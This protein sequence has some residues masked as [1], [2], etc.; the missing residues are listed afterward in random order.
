MNNKWMLEVSG[1]NTRVFTNSRE[2]IAATKK[3][4]KAG[5]STWLSLKREWAAMPDM[6][7]I[8]VIQ[9]DG[10]IYQQRANKVRGIAGEMIKYI[11]EMQKGVK[12]AE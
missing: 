1:E 8:E 7:I 10:V 5:K 9:K 4:I 6:V 3:S 11:D 2:A 12:Y